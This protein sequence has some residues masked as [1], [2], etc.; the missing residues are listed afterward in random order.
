[1]NID[2]W[3]LSIQV[4]KVMEYEKWDGIIPFIPI[5]SGWLVKVRPPMTG[6]IVRFGIT[7]EGLGNYVSVYLDCYGM[8]GV[9]N[10]PY[11]EIYPAANGDTARYNVTDI[12]GLVSGIEDALNAMDVKEGSI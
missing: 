3:E 12:E 9:V 4:E 2:R 5:K 8:L 7:K 1:M 6:A 10:Y 11:W